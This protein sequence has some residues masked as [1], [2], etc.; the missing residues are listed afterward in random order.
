[1]NL[2]KT[3]AILA[4]VALAAPAL[5]AQPSAQVSSQEFLKAIQQAPAPAA[6]SIPAPDASAPSTPDAAP[7]ACAVGQVEDDD[8]L[9]APVVK[10][11]GFSLATSGAATSA[12]AAPRAR[13][14]VQRVA[15]LA[16]R[17]VVA[18]A[19]PR[20]SRLSDLLITFRLGSAELTEQGR[21]NAKSFADALRDPSVASIH[22]EIAGHTD[23]SGAADRNTVLS[24]ARADSVKAFLVSQ[25]VDADR[26]ESKGYGSSDLAD[27]GHPDAA[28]NRRVEARRLD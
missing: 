5:A 4:A 22:F 19:P 16:P 9:C 25:G 21:L 27:P 23:A 17:H 20:T 28:A 7:A 6:P 18:A 2:L 14:P 8:G 12:P 10:T 3:S 13:P 15:A 26:L 11:R 1:M 24:Q